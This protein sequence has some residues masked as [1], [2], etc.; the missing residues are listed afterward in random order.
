MSL[1]SF[2]KAP[3]I[4]EVIIYGFLLTYLSSLTSY[5]FAEQEYESVELIEGVTLD[6]E[7]A[8]RFSTET[9]GDSRMSYAGGPFAITTNSKGL[10]I[11]SHSQH[12][13]IAEFAVPELKTSKKASELNFA[14]GLQSFTSI[15]KNKKRLNNPQ[16]LDRISGMELIE[17]ELFVN[18]VEYYDAPGDNNQTT[19]IIR[20]PQNLKKSEVDGLFQLQGGAH[21]AGW[22]SKIPKSVRND[23]IGSYLLG[24][25]NNYAIN[26]RFSIGPSAYASNID[27]FAGIPENKGLIPAHKLMDYS[28]KKPIHPDQYNEHKKNNIW[29]EVSYAAYGFINPNGKYY[30]V[31]GNSGGHES[32]IGYKIKQNNG[33]MCG[34]PCARD[35][36]DYYNYYWIFDVQDLL[37]AQDKKIAPHTI[38]PIKV[39]KLAIP[40]QPRNNLRKIIGADFDYNSNKLWMLIENVDYSQSEFETA[41]VMVIYKLSEASSLMTKTDNDV[42]R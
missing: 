20:Q 10:Y 22:I 24:Y 30:I 26:S 23:F 9:W 32:S 21:A 15:L 6:Y 33:N 40:F 29:T 2:S 28:I 36:K 1:F 27:A 31:V 25:T 38:R 4:P 39:G 12:Q 37:K 14:I 8:F 42:T 17:G 5:A 18:A 35:A 41:P 19:F 11:V 13:A 34:G 7:G 16:K 3:S